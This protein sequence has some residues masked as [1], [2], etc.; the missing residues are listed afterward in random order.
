MG[1]FFI[2]YSFIPMTY[3]INCDQLFLNDT[4]VPDEDVKR[5]LNTLPGKVELIW[6]DL[7]FSLTAKFSWSFKWADKIILPWN[8]WEIFKDFVSIPK[9]VSIVSVTPKRILAPWS[10][11]PR[12]VDIN[13]EDINTLGSIDRDSRVLIWDD[14]VASWSTINKLRKKLPQKVS[15]SMRVLTL[16]LRRDNQLKKNIRIDAWVV[17]WREGGW[18]PWI[19]TL[20]TLSCPSKSK[21]VLDWFE[22]KYWEK[23]KTQI[24]ELFSV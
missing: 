19:N 23:F 12:W 5:V 10:L 11:S 7:L 2:V 13:L 1:E 4:G 8:W 14:V 16:I 9:N 21:L 3:K 6:K 22:R 20:S 15:E 18:F 17:V 24:A